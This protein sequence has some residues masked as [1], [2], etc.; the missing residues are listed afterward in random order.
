M[1][2]NDY[3]DGESCLREALKTRERWNGMS[4]PLVAEVLDELAGVMCNSKN[5][6]RLVSGFTLKLGGYTQTNK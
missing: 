4:H 2:K 5:I 3:K 1:R 6:E